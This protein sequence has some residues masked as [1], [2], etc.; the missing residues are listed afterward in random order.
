MFWQDLNALNTNTLNMQIHRRKAVEMLIQ[1]F[2]FAS[3]FLMR[4]CHQ[5]TL[6]QHNKQLKTL[7]LLLRKPQ[8][9]LMQK[10]FG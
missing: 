1:Q 3:Y 5:K 10:N 8:Q 6:S 2:N 4:N 9:M 7:D